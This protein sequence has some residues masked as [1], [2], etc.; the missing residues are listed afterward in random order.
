MYILRLE[1]LY[2]V[3]E[4]PLLAELEKFSHAEMVWCQEEPRNMGAWS[5]IEPELERVLKTLGA[6]HTRLHY[7]GRR[8]SASTA[9]GLLSRHMNER[10]ALLAGALS[11]PIG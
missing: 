5:F 4:G 3:P 7:A 11:E 10:D 6:K 8:A 1:Q 9:T 2:P